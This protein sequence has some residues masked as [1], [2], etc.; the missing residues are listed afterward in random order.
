MGTTVKGLTA[1]GTADQGPSKLLALCSVQPLG[2]ANTGRP[3]VKV[4]RIGG[5]SG[6]T[7][8]T[9]KVPSTGK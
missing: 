1:P 4:T 2:Q 7:A 5:R 6:G 8:A 3:P 9:R